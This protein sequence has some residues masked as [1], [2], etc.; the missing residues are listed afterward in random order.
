MN[1]E[2][3]QGDE[4]FYIRRPGKSVL[5]EK[6]KIIDVCQSEASAAIKDEASRTSRK[7]L[8]G[9][10]I[11]EVSQPALSFV[12]EPLSG[13]ERITVKQGEIQSAEK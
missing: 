5:P 1:A 9:K 11:Q 7:S 8:Y 3:K 4:V 2:F 10:E 12:I 6:F 13:G